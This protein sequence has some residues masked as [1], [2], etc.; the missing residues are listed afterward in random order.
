MEA[1]A[2]VEAD[3]RRAGARAGPARR[4]GALD[5]ARKGWLGRR[6]SSRGGPGSLATAEGHQPYSSNT[7]CV[8][9]WGPTSASG[10]GRGLEM[11]PGHHGDCHRATEAI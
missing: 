10:G 5:A 8:S 4:A 11:H 2:A 1:A 3:A 7:R 6:V 9:V